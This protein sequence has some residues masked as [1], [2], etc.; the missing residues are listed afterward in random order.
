MEPLDVRK[1]PIES[2]SIDK[3]VTN[4]PFGHQMS[5]PISLPDLYRSAFTEFAR[6]TRPGGRAVLL[7][8]D[9]GN[10]RETL[11][12]QSAWIVRRKIEIDLLGQKPMLLVLDRPTRK[13]DD[14]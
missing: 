5:D 7:V 12:G 1:L 2:E 3:I 14:P 8:S 13:A 6:V 10:W 9:A 11:A 4:M